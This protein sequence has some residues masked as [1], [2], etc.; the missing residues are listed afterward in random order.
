[1]MKILIVGGDGMLGHQLLHTLQQQHDVR[2]TLRQDLAV[3]SKDKLFTQ[4]NSYVGV[5]VRRFEELL[6]AIADFQ[7]QAIVNAVGIVKQRKSAKDILPSLEINALFPHRLSLFCKTAGIRLIHI[8]TDCIFSGRKGN[9]TEADT[10][11]AEDVYGKTKY[12]GEL[13]EPHCVTLRSSIIGLELYHKSG[14]IEWFL[15]QKGNI[16]GFT[17]AI[18][19]GLTTQEM[20]RVI[21]RVLVKHP[22]ISGVWHVSSDQAVNKYE[23]LNVFSELL[24]RKDIRIE[25]DEDFICDRSLLSEPFKEITGYKPPSWQVMLSELANQVK[26]RDY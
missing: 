5:D 4:E 6:N 1:M 14:L 8:S 9:Y 19:S 21:D 17:K 24:G 25:R 16:K 13:S 26:Q 3:Y 18:Y 11:D 15:A 10:S 12:L 20:S 22:E 2:V 23:L 7:P